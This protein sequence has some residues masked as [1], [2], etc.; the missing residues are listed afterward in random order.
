VQPRQDESFLLAALLPQPRAKPSQAK[1]SGP[2]TAV[3]AYL[4]IKSTR[5][6]LSSN[7]I[8]HRPAIYLYRDRRFASRMTL[9]AAFSLSISREWTI[10]K[11]RQPSIDCSTSLVCKNRLGAS[12]GFRTIL[13]MHES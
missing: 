1:P 11:S 12:Q 4:A 7:L 13:S 8:G 10:F 5:P 3:R 6:G 2:T 9:R